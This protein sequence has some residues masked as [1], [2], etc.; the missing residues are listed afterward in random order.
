L[1]QD[2]SKP[3]GKVH[4]IHRDG[5]IPSDNPFLTNETALPSI[6]SYGHRNPQG[7]AVHPQTDRLWDSE[8]GPMGGDEVNAI[9][10]GRNYGWPEIS[11]GRH[12]NGNILTR[13]EA[14]AGMEQ[15]TWV[16]RP[17]TGVCGL[18]I[19][20][21]DQFPKWQGHL[22]VG[23]LKYESVDLLMVDG[24]RVIHRETIVKNLGRVRDV[25]VGPEGAVY[26]VLNGPDRVI[27]LTAIV[28][29]IE[30]TQ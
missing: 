14:K 17:S 16:Y 1:A 12:Y 18:D 23:S 7:L 30:A 21:G 3:N 28:D 26:V 6:F 13:F 10:G 29:R 27:R 25:A 2:L 15:P 24:D 20:R 8:H 11:Y 9:H 4:R 19:Y 22:L 5:T